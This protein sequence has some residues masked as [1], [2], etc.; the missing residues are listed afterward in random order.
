M[1]I[2][3]LSI[4]LQLVMWSLQSYN[5]INHIIAGYVIIMILVIFS[6]YLDGYNYHRLKC[7]VNSKYGLITH[8]IDVYIRYQQ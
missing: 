6:K 5:H 4:T 1:N 7:V 8:I 2:I 3:I